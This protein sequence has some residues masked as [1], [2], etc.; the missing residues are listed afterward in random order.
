[1]WRR[2]RWFSSD[3]CPPP[4]LA[5]A[6]HAG[7]INF[8]QCETKWQEKISSARREHHLIGDNADTLKKTKQWID[9][10]WQLNNTHFKTEPAGVSALN[11]E[12]IHVSEID[13]E[14]L[15]VQDVQAWMEAGDWLRSAPEGTGEGWQPV[16]DS[17]LEL[18]QLQ[19][20]WIPHIQWPLKRKKN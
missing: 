14:D 20:S 11:L 4:P 8:S 2:M 10:D 15:D 3:K 17:C 1:M 7:T 18:E 6:Q 19:V 5:S 13:R 16:K 12:F 9:L